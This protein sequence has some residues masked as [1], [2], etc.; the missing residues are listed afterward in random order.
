MEFNQSYNF[1]NLNRKTLNGKVNFSVKSETSRLVIVL[2]Q[3]Y[4]ELL[5]MQVPRP[6]VDQRNPNLRGRALM[7]VDAKV[8]KKFPGTTETLAGWCCSCEI[9]MA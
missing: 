9:R 4:R 6:H 2:N 5:R 1:L 3:S 7:A 8:P